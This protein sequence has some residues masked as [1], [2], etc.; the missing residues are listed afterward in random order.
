LVGALFAIL[1]VML[2]FKWQWNRDNSV[3]Q[4]LLAGKARKGDA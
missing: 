3:I 4:R 1:A 2:W